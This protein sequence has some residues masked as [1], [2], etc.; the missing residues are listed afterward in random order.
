MPSPPRRLPHLSGDRIVNRSFPSRNHF[1]RA[2]SVEV[3]PINA[4]F[5]EL[6]THI[7]RQMT[8]LHIPG[9]V[10]AVVEGDYITHLCGFGRAG[11]DGNTPTP[12]TPFFIGTL[13]KSFT[14]V[15]M[16]QLVETGK[17]DL[18]APV[19]QYLPWFR[20]ADRLASAQITVRYLLNQTSGLP[21]SC[22]S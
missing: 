21:T 4:T 15:A 1:V 8:S 10:L 2:T 3:T 14:A 11:P 22:L 20:L 13:T 9:A 19:Q 5:D 6:D 7:Q 17:I 18:D 16:M 12:Q